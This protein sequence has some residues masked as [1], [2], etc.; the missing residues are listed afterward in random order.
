MEETNTT[1][2]DAN[3]ALA[4]DY[5]RVMTIGRLVLDE[6]HGHYDAKLQGKI[7]QVLPGIMEIEE[8]ESAQRVEFAVQQERDMQHQ[9]LEKMKR[10]LCTRYAGKI[11]RLEAEEEKRAGLMEQLIGNACS[12]RERV[13]ELA[14]QPPIL[15]FKE[16]P[17]I[18]E[19][20]MMSVR[21]LL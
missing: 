10:V 9:K 11:A 12:Q 21:Y 16:G 18:F 4:K 19:E 6:Q 13:L 7:D 2:L 3:D 20:S 14:A 15:E 5:Q 17:T 8:F 1:E